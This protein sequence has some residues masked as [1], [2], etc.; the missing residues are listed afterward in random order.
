[1]F[2][3]IWSVCGKLTTRGT[4]ERECAKMHSNGEGVLAV[5]D[6]EH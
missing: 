5:I 1:M 2:L 6:F 4:S 3:K